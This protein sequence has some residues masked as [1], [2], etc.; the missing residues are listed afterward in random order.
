MGI[1]GKLF[2]QRY[3]DRL[4]AEVKTVEGVEKTTKGLKGFLFGKRK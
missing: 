2:G 3:T 1:R 4:K